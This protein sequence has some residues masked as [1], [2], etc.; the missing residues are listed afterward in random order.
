MNTDHGRIVVFGNEKGGTGK[1]T[2]AMHVVVSLLQADRTVA[3]VDLD[4]RQRS[5]TRYIENR[6]RF[7]QDRDIELQTPHVHEIE[8]SSRSDLNQRNMED[9]SK[10]QALVDQLRIHHDFTVIDCPGNYTPLS[11]NAHVMADTLV[12]PVNDSF[13]D[14]D[15]IGQI[16]PETFELERYSQ[17]A[18][19][20][21]TAR[22]QRAV[23]RK[24]PT[25]WVVARN[26]IS[27]QQAKNRRRV[28]YALTQLQKRCGFRYVAGLSE[29][30]IYRELFP[31]GLT[32]MDYKNVPALG[33]LSMSQVAARQEIRQ[34]VDDL[35]LLPAE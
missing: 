6:Q 14:L 2:L 19:T 22:K 15:V 17:Y 21:W 1:S 33:K 24:T 23:A 3:I 8:P 10:L 16:H 7:Q 31:V 34:L 25:D 12:T 35:L 30:V 11:V 32:L 9:A 29:R 5:L 26:R 20:V 13:I 28:H 4:V 18:E 27:I